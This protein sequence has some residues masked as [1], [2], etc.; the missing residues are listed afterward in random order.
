MRLALALLVSSLVAPWPA[1]A[2]QQHLPHH[3]FQLGDFAL[4]R[5]GTLPGAQVLYVTHGT[6]NADRSNAILVPSWYGGN[7]HG[8][9]FLIGG[10]RAIDPADW[11]VI[12]TEMFASGGSTSPSNMSPPRTHA[13][14]PEVTIR[15]NVEATRRLVTE[16]F[17]ITHLRAIIGFSM[18]AEQAFQ[19]AVSHPDFMDLIVPI[20]G[21]AKTYP[22]GIVRLESALTLIT[23]D[24]EILAGR[25]TLSTAGTRAW[26]L[27]WS[28][29]TRST[30]WWRREIFRSG[31]TP[32]VEAVIAAASRRAPGFRPHDSVVQGR[33]WQLHDIGDT[34]GFGGDV[35]RALASIRARVLYLPGATDMY[36]PLTDAEY[37]RSFLRNVEF[38]PIPSVWGH[39]AGGGSDP[40]DRAFLNEVIGRELRR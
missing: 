15:D 16:A 5:G 30:E 33:V 24:P 32:T 20:A 4:E 36:F 35:E 23:Q 9:D 14:F 12:V 21:T 39:M 29:W 2:Q 25:D 11:F 19:W 10:D 27:H 13:T 18:G 34:P 3:Y 31:A 6:L 26:S 22:H 17:G 37:E 38:V 28:A 40:A 7:H 8:Y 1:A